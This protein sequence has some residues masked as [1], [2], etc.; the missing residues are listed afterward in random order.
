ME[1][2]C[3]SCGEAPRLKCF[4]LEEPQYFCEACL[5]PHILSES[6]LRHITEEITCLQVSQ[7]NLCSQCETAKP[8]VFCTCQ[9]EIMRLCQG[10]ILYHINCFP[11]SSHPLEPVEAESLIRNPGD[12]KT[13]VERKQIV[14]CLVQ[15][16]RTNLKTLDSFRQET[17]KSI[18]V[19]AELLQTYELEIDQ[20]IKDK[21]SFLEQVIEELENAKYVE[22]LD[23]SNWAQALVKKCNS[24]NVS[25]I[26]KE[27]NLIS[28]QVN[29]ESAVEA[30]KG[31]ATVKISKDPTRADPVVYYIKP[32]SKEFF[33]YKLREANSQKFCFPENLK[34]KDVGGWCEV[35][36][37]GVF[38]CGGCDNENFSNETYL[39]DETTLNPTRLP[40]MINARAFPAIVHYKNSIYVFGG[41]RGSSIKSCEKFDLLKKFW[42]P[43][44]DMPRPR[45]AFSV[46]VLDNKFYMAGDNKAIDIFDPETNEFK[47]SSI[48]LEETGSYTT[49]VGVENNL[50]L[51]QNDKVWE[52]NP[53]SQTTNV[54]ARIPHSK[55]WS[56]F[57]PIVE[58]LNIYF[59]RYDENSLWNFNLGTSEFSR[60]HKF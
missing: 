31:M 29:L 27:L 34:L 14:E 46:A 28:T 48:V 50:V 52:I 55:W 37:L 4:C 35:P 2:F 54:L 21:K 16:A 20:Q 40:D 25:K 58:D 60:V 1:P 36:L 19:L 47:E 33:F 45:S 51:F 13:Y 17:L 7:H 6:K 18:K 22:C 39:I 57:P 24:S 42:T 53:S 59:S 49:M 11:R 32:R 56:Q 38:F 30:I 5:T 15:E 23:E 3:K 41:Y 44:P 26:A 8:H 9:G 10:C 43:L 12:L